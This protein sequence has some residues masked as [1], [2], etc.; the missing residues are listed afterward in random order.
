MILALV[1]T[2]WAG[3]AQLC[4]GSE[5]RQAI[6]NIFFFEVGDRAV[7]TLHDGEGFCFAFEE[8]SYTFEVRTY[9]TDPVTGEIEEWPIRFGHTLHADTTTHLEVGLFR[10]SAVAIDADS[11]TKSHELLYIVWRDASWWDTVQPRTV[12]DKRLSHR[13]FVLPELPPKPDPTKAEREAIDPSIF[14]LDEDE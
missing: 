2:L 9:Y 12:P 1:G 14:D 6:K 5:E 8:G 7:A 11:V 13:R 4:L 10:R 3:D